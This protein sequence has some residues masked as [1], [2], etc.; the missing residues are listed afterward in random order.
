MSQIHTVAS[1][2]VDARYIPLGDQ[3]TETKRRKLNSPG[4]GTRRKLGRVNFRKDFWENHWGLLTGASPITIPET[5]ARHIQ[6]PVPSLQCI[7]FIMVLDKKKL[8][9][10]INGSLR[11]RVTKIIQN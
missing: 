1:K 3:S 4:L 6:P 10:G 8:V 5:I 9:N 2:L 11:K 7:V